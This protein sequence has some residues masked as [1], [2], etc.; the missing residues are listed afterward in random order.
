MICQGVKD[1]M[2]NRD[3]QDYLKVLEDS[4]MCYIKS[5][6]YVCMD[7]ETRVSYV[8]SYEE[9]KALLINLIEIR[10]ILGLANIAQSE[11]CNTKTVTKPA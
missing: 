7:K 4:F 11:V 2:N 3:C 1:F 9:L 10:T 8:S 5:E 6:E